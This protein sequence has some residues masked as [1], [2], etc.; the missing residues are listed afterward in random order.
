MTTWSRDSATGFVL[1]PS[2]RL[3]GAN[4]DSS[5]SVQQLDPAPERQERRGVRLFSPTLSL[6][7]PDHLPCP[8]SV[9]P[10]LIWWKVRPLPSSLPTLPLTQSRST[11][12]QALPRQLVDPRRGRLLRRGRGVRPRR[13][14]QERA[15]ERA[16]GAPAR[17]R[18][19][20]RQS[21]RRVRIPLA[22][23]SFR[24]SEPKIVHIPLP[25]NH[26]LGLSTSLF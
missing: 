22:P 11:A 16:P 8:F 17:T 2:R 12:R 4:P 19:P 24:H 23:L 7:T 13:R 15:P 10:E 26:P 5:P 18:A 6:Q 1:C 20:G 14:A 3:P 25:E 9:V 21:P